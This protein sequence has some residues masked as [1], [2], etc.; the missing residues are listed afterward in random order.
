MVRGIWMGGLNDDAGEWRAASRRT[1]ADLGTKEK[2]RELEHQ[3]ARITLLNQALWELVRERLS[4]TDADL[5]RMAR[6]VD[7]RDGIED[8]K[9]T[10]TPLE[11]P[12]CGRVSSSKHWK[13][14]YCG[15]LFEKPIMG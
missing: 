2:I 6:E 9:L 10:I 12:S 3:I 5:E 11:C 1:V 15:Q 13:C 8:G 14:L 4:L 7:I